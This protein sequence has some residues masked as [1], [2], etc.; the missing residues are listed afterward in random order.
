MRHLP[1]AILAIGRNYAE[2]AREMGVQVD[3]NPIIFMKSPA[4]VIRD[5]DTIETPAICREH[6]PAMW[7]RPTRSR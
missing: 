3:P 1:T 6:G 7:R 4:S 5:G 2:L